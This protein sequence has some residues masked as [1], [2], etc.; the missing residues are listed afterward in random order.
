MIYPH[1]NRPARLSVLFLVV[2]FCQFHSSRALAIVDAASQ[3]NTNA[4]SDGSPWTSVGR[5]NGG[6]CT[7]LGAGWVLTANHVFAGGGSVNLDGTLYPYDGTS[8]RLTNSDGTATDF[9]VMHLGTLPPLPRMPLMTTAPAVSSTVDMMGFGPIAGSLQTNFG[10]GLI[11][12]TWSSNPFKSWGNNTVSGG[13]GVVN[14]GEGNVTVFP[15]TFDEF[16]QTS[17]E[18]QAAPGDSGGGVFQKSGSTWELVGMLLY[19]SQPLSGQPLNTSCYGQETFLG[20][21]ATYRGQILAWVT[22]T[23]P[24]LSISQAGTNVM[25]CWPDTGVT[26]TLLSNHSLTMTNWAVLSPTLT[27]TNGQYCAVIPTTS[28]PTFFRLHR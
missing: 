6:G 4:P 9:V 19:T 25:V 10:S 21:I 16:G 23:V 22:N 13:L 27:L 28:S 17:D 7:Y 11:G 2:A 18:A 14:A 26:W 3:S 15:T 24:S 20:N 1:A 5:L 12:F 8:A